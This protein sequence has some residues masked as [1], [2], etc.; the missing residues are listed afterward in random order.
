MLTTH[1]YAIPFIYSNILD[2]ESLAVQGRVV[3][4]SEALPVIP[5]SH[6]QDQVLKALALLC[7]L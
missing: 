2:G 3:L 7:S 5:T 1:E 4:R 6:I